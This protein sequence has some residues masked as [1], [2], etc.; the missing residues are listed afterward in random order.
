MELRRQGEHRAIWLDIVSSLRTRGRMSRLLWQRTLANDGS[1]STH[2]VLDTTRNRR[3]VVKVVPCTSEQEVATMMDDVFLQ[4]RVASEC[5]SCVN[6][7]DCFYHAIT[8]FG[9]GYFLVVIIYE[10]GVG[11][12]LEHQVL[13]Q[14]AWDKIIPP[15]PPDYLQKEREIKQWI[16]DHDDKGPPPISDDKVLLWTMQIAKGLQKLHENQFIHRNLKPSNVFLTEDGNAMIGDYPITKTFEGTLPIAATYTGGPT[17]LAPELLNENLMF[18]GIIGPPIDVWSLGCTIYYLCS[19]L[20][21]CLTAEGNLPKS[22][23]KLLD[24]VPVRFGRTVRDLIKMTL[25]WD[26]DERA[27]LDEIMQFVGDEQLARQEAHEAE[28]RHRQSIIDLFERVD[29]DQSGA[30]DMDELFHAIKKDKWVKRLLGRNDRLQPLLQPKKARAM[31]NQIDK[32]GDG[33]VTLDELLDF[34]KVMD[35]ATRHDRDVLNGL[36]KMFNIVDRDH[37]L[38]VEKTELLEAINTRPDV[39]ETL[40]QVEKLRPLLNTKTFKDTFMRM[41]TNNGGSITLD[42]MIEFSG[43][44]RTEAE[45]RAELKAQRKAERRI[46]KKLAQ[47]YR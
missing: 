16:K 40:S 24:A 28:L 36:V 13:E 26:I 22:M 35:F 18:P 2:D 43:I 12:E 4:R 6:V 46:A 9:G 39:R 3:Y 44:V 5:L 10:C 31:F 45:K 34:C 25:V 47:Q 29:A 37:S 27:T 11:G 8:G 23:D 7:D 20:E 41:D 32:N 42:E 17:Y 15:P 38:T 1:I 21:I 19:G 14:A 33:V 30:I